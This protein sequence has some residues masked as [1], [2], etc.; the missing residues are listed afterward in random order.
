MAAAARTAAAR[1]AAARTAATAERR[2][3]RSGRDGPTGD[4]PAGTGQPG[5]GQPGTGQPGTGQSGAAGS[6]NGAASGAGAGAGTTGAGTTGAG[7]A[8]NGAAGNGASPNGA[9]GNGTSGNGTSGNGN[10]GTGN[11]AAGSATSGSG[12]GG[13]GTSANGTSANG[14]SANGT[15]ANGTT[16]QGAAANGASGNGTSEGSPAGGATGGGAAQTGTAGQSGSGQQPAGAKPA[17]QNQP[18]TNQPGTN[19]PGT[20]QPG[21]N[22]P[23][24]NQPG[25]NQ[26]GQNQTGT[27]QTGQ[28]QTGQNQTDQNQP[29]ANQTGTDQSG[30]SQTG[31]NQTGQNQMGPATNGPGAPAGASG[32]PSTRNLDLSVE[33][34]GLS[35]GRDGATLWSLSFPDRTGLTAG[36]VQSGGNVY[37]GHGNSLLVLDASSG[38][39]RARYA[40]PAQVSDVAMDGEAVAATV[41]FDDG[42]EQRLLLAP[43]GLSQRVRFEANPAMFAWLRNEAEVDDPAARLQQDPTNPWLYLAVAEA[44]SGANAQ[45]S[46]RQALDHAAT[47]YDLAGIARRLVADGQPDLANEAM[48]SAL[49]DYWSRGYRAEL[50]TDPTLRDAYGFA[51]QP[52]QTALDRGDLQTAGFWAPWVYRMSTPAVPDTQATLR[53]YSRALRAAG[54]RDQASLWR[55]RANE[56]SRFTVAGSLDSGALAI[57]RNGW[58]GVAALILAILALHGTLI[59]KYWRPQGLALRQQRESGRT[60]SRV[61]RLFAMRYYSL[62]EKLVL[63]L[64]FAA[65]LALASLAGWARH[66]TDLPAAWRSGTLAS[67]PARNA[68]PEVLGTSPDA[69]FVAGFAAQTAGD[70]RKA[71]QAYADAGDLPAAL[72]NLGVLQNDDALF[73]AAL[74]AAPRMPE[75][76]FNL[77]QG[78]DPS[79]LHAAYAPDAKLLAVPGPAALRAAVGGPFQN[80]LGAAFTNP[81]S[82]LVGLDPLGVPQ[83]LWDTLVV[84]FLAWG[85][86]SVIALLIPRPRI[87]ANA[88]RTLAYHVL[89]LLIPGSGLSDELW[90]VLLLVPWA[91]FGIDTLIHVMPIGAP[92]AFALATDYAALGVIYALNVVSFVVE[93]I[94]YRRRMNDLKRNHPETARAYGMRAAPPAERN[95]RRERAS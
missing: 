34:G 6:A 81:W 38:T 54:R 31:Q 28:N 18:G 21:T 17:G 71:A 55:N 44:A 84:L 83:W 43:G 88:P 63:V 37:L 69:S 87:A 11:A 67:V 36:I 78:P 95:L 24:T 15:S 80:A 60:P 39:V 50:L 68:L 19:Q 16:E 23:G 57:G 46:Y 45:Q 20:N 41:R 66:G 13:N 65:T 72:N 74:D 35:A 52:L 59:A 1:T 64:L 3:D 56:S 10:A 85:V 7:T 8:G 92:A 82:A 53:E 32:Q 40:L 73:Q 58:Y 27:N 62:T 94:S 77:G 70:T 47:F 33:N 76:A 9:A 2:N 75:P 30:Q 51:L 5:T 49:R 91:I 25:T 61:P 4:G 86:V 14:T 42:S 26:T 89:A 48:D 29:G 90:G 22:Q 79:R 93:F 12:T